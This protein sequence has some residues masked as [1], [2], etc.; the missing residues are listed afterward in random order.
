MANIP[1]NATADDL[2]NWKYKPT[3]KTVLTASG[4]VKATDGTL[5]GIFVSASSS[6]NLCVY[7][8]IGT[9]TILIGTVAVAAKDN[10]IFPSVKF[11]NSLNVVVV[12]GTLTATIFYK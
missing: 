12:S 10:F 11:S 3:N 5:E 4:T 7:D 2:R 8:S 9:S 6:G 1:T